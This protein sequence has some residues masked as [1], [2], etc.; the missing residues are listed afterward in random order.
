MFYLKYMIGYVMI[1]NC[2]SKTV[3]TNNS[4]TYAVCTQKNA[5][6]MMTASRITNSSA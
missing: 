3:Y 2:A 1:L 5:K 4:L 6:I